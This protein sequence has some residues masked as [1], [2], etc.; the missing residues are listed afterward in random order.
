M[1]EKNYKKLADKGWN[2]MASVLDKEMP[3]R[4]DNRWLILLLFLGLI[5]LGSGGIYLLSRSPETDVTSKG[6]IAVVGNEVEEKTEIAELLNEENAMQ[7][8]QA[9]K[10]SAVLTEKERKTDKDKLL[11]SPLDT[12]GKY[13]KVG[14]LTKEVASTANEE[15]GEGTRASYENKG[16][17]TEGRDAYVAGKS[18]D[19][20]LGLSEIED[21]SNSKGDEMIASSKAEPSQ[22]LEEVSDTEASRSQGGSYQVK[23]ITKQEIGTL[24]FEKSTPTM[25]SNLTTIEKKYPIYISLYGGYSLPLASR[26]SGPFAGVEVGK[27]ISPRWSWSSRLGI[28]AATNNLG[29]SFNKEDD[30]S[31]LQPSEM[32]T[33]P[34]TT[35]PDEQV[36]VNEM[37]N[38]EVTLHEE[39]YNLVIERLGRLYYLDL[40]LNAS[41]AISP[42]SQV[43]AGLTYSYLF[44]SKTDY[45]S[46]SEFVNTLAE[47]NGGLRQDVLLQTN[48]VNRHNFSVMGTYRYQISERFA[49]SLRM[50]FGLNQIL[51]VN[52]VSD[53]RNSLN[54]LGLAF[55]YKLKM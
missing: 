32:E 21:S 49:M 20:H 51:K 47:S 52:E 30:A 4:S 34:N 48:L 27:N 28:N 45:I 43:G 35:T 13:K 46:L 41:Y 15:S 10:G 2:N 11:E 31:A 53:Y 17:A 26:I 24:V 18:G 40:G 3:V 22:G 25:G 29:Q 12:E 5:S 19:A 9:S 55:D 54:Y 50:N 23:D 14:S 8:S 38:G 6:D 39:Y 7:G 1:P 33:D 16:G 42:K 37:S 36:L 44:S